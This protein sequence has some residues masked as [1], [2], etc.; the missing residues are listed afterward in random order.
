VR[1]QKLQQL[2]LPGQAFQIEWRMLHM[3]DHRPIASQKEDIVCIAAFESLHG[4]RY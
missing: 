1:S 4:D 2:M 3:E